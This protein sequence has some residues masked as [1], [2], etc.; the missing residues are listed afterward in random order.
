M[1]VDHISM[2]CNMNHNTK[3]IN[4]VDHNH[5]MLVSVRSIANIVVISVLLLLCVD[6][7]LAFLTGVFCVS[8]FVEQPTR[9]RRKNCS[10]HR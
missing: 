4:A 9:C 2:I 3:M 7:T 10:I 5:D 1:I 6:S 8:R